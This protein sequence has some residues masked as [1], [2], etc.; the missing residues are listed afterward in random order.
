MAEC[1][2]PSCVTTVSSNKNLTS[3]LTI[4]IE[5]LVSC[6][7]VEKQKLEFKKSW[8][9]GPTKY[10]I[11]KT[12]SAFANDFYNDNGGYIVI[13]IT[14]QEDDTLETDKQIV[15]PPFGI[16]PKDIERIQKE[17]IGACKSF[18]SPPYT[19][20]LSPEILEGKHVLVIWA[21]ASDDRPHK[22]RVAKKGDSYH[23]IR[24]GPETVKASDDEVKTLLEN[25]AKIPFDDRMARHGTCSDVSK[26]VVF[27]LIELLIATV[28]SHIPIYQFLPS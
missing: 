20:I 17:I 16:K 25:S 8:N 19:P 9:D 23:F 2:D 6:Q 1:P 5:D 13:G 11:I 26:C 21:Q 15:L 10:Q 14:E 7:S 24:K 3:N 18:I 12:I 22:A 4:N 28:I 27:I